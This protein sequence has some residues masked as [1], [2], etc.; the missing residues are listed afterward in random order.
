V[1]GVGGTTLSSL[2]PPPRETVWNNS[3]GASGGGISSMWQMPSYQS[4]AP[5]A[6]G[7]INAQSAGSPCGSSGYCREVPDVSADADP[8]TGYEIFW[9]GG[10][11]SFGGTSAA[12]PTWAALIALANASSACTRTRVGFANGAIYRAAAAN[13]RSDFNDVASGSN[14]H[15]GVAGFSSRS[16]FDMASGLGTPSSGTLAAALCGSADTVS[17]TNPGPQ[18]AP[19]GTVTSLHL[20]ATSSAGTPITFA[21][22][23]LPAGLAINPS[24]GLITGTPTSAGTWTVHATAS[25][26][27]SSTGAA[28]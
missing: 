4:N 11:S 10:W 24:S 13:Y 8:N 28:S 5:A 21:A 7:V 14:S 26:A 19:A 23:G 25:D 22:S 6:L 3:S 16:G 9:N 12:A 27:S 2:G 18:S 1:T 20:N 17:I 15:N